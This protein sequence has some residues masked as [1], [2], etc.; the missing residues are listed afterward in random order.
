[1]ISKVTGIANIPFQIKSYKVKNK[2]E[3]KKSTFKDTKSTFDFGVYVQKGS[4]LI[5]KKFINK[6]D[7]LDILI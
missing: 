3:Y 4:K 7:K 6:G 1:M 5:L 2:I